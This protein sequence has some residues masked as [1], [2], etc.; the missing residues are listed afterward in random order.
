[1]SNINDILNN[2]D[3]LINRIQ[4]INNLQLLKKSIIGYDFD[5]VLHVD[6]TPADS[7][8]QKHPLTYVGPYKPFDKIITQIKDQLNKNHKIYV[9]TARHKSSKPHI[10]HF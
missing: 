5:G 9:V 7:T 6:V 1:M 3:L 8:G 10:D 2:I 4:I